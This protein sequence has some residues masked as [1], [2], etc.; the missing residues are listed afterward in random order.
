[1]GNQETNASNNAKE[2]RS[3]RQQT[4]ALAA[5]AD[6]NQTVTVSAQPTANGGNKASKTESA[7][8]ES[9]TAAPPSITKAASNRTRRGAEDNINSTVQNSVASTPSG[10]SPAQTRNRKAADETTNAST[11]GK[12]N[13]GRTTRKSVAHDTSSSSSPADLTTSSTAPSN[14]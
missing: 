4:A 11:N 3:A 5:A 10:M 6:K 2:R 7:G 9:A 12:S 14:N 8:V 1:M 13:P